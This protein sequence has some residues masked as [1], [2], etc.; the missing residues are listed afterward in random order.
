MSL[1]LVELTIVVV[2]ITDLSDYQLYKLQRVLNSSARL[3]LCAPRFS[4]RTYAKMAAFILLFYS[5][6]KEPH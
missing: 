1:Q 6:L 3:V 4:H 2:F 5:Y